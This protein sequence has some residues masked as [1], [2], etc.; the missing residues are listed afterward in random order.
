MNLAV[1]LAFKG[2]FG[3]WPLVAAHALSSVALGLVAGTA[4]GTALRLLAG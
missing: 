1:L 4:L 3:I 2:R